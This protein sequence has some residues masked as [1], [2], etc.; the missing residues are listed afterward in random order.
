MYV[1][2]LET[3]H[4]IVLKVIMLIYGMLGYVS[5]SL[6]NKLVSRELV[7]VLIKLKFSESKVCEVC[8]K[9]KQVRSSFKLRKQVSTS[10]ILE[11]LHMDL[12]GP[13]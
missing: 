6:L 7:L 13:L 5:S 10:R 3:S 4:D 11:L 8:V 12:C 9:A 1:A 2:K